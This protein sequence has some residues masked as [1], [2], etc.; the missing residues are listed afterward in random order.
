M[1]FCTKGGRKS[2]KVND[3]IYTPEFIVKK[4]MKE[5]PIKS[6]DTLLDAFAGDM[7]FYNN[8]PEDNIKFWCEIDKG[9]DFYEFNKKVDWII[10]NPP[11]SDYEN[12]IKHSFD[13]ADNIVYLIPL[14]KIVSSWG[15]ILDLE[16]YGGVKKLWIFPA[17]KANFPFGFPAC[18]VW[19]QR[20][21]KGNIETE[22][23]K[24]L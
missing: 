10:T 13:I 24:D 14:G 3:K 15:R 4:I 6:S 8:Y 21:Y 23:W 7:V 9:K 17:G 22:L 16:N 5:L 18:Y 1:G 20:G 19:M 12:L 11:Y 2:N